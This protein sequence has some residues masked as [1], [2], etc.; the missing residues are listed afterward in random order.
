MKPVIKTLCITI[1]SLFL[2]FQ[3]ASAEET[4]PAETTFGISQLINGTDQ[5]TDNVI[6]RG[7]VSKI[8]PQDKLISL[9]D[10]PDVKSGHKSMG[11]QCSIASSNEFRH[12]LPHGCSTNR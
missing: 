7:F 2:V 6:V 8:F 3:M 9:I 4:A 11:K 10:H 12:R 5:N 1:F